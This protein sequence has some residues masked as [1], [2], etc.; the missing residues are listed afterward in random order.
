MTAHTVSPLLMF[1]GFSRT[2]AAAR[3]RRL[4]ADGWSASELARFFS[5]HVDEVVRIISQDR[6][7]S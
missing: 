2:E 6:V 4:H 3:I 5:V 1:Y 7:I